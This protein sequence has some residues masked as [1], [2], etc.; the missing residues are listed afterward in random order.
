MFV[1]IIILKCII[2]W[3]YY[4]CPFTVFFQLHSRSLMLYLAM[5]LDISRPLLL[6]Q[7]VLYESIKYGELIGNLLRCSF[8]A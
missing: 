5:L 2:S 8:V 7:L 3:Y 1:T 6:L 4:L